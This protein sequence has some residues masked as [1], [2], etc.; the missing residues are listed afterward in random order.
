M[1]C[2]REGEMSER[3]REGEFLIVGGKFK[4]CGVIEVK[5]RG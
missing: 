5:R 2:D 4:L 3:F 1:N